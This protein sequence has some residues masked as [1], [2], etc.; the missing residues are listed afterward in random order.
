MR[1]DHGIVSPGVEY[2][3]ISTLREKM[4]DMKYMR[5]ALLNSGPTVAIN[6]FINLSTNAA[7]NVRY[8]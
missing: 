5:C 2:L 6:R 8:R 7:N 1:Y 3:F 4:R